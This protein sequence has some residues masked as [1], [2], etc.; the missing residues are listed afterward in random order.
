MLKGREE[1]QQAVDHLNEESQEEVK[2][3]PEVVHFPVDQGD[4]AALEAF[5]RIGLLYTSRV[6]RLQRAYVKA[7]RAVNATPVSVS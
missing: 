5:A 3:F 6:E 2:R 7:L 1:L 4:R